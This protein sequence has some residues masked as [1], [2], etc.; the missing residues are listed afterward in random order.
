MMSSGLGSLADTVDMASLIWLVGYSGYCASKAALNIFTLKFA[1]EPLADGI[2][3]NAVDP[4]FTATDLNGHTGHRFVE[5][6][7]TIA[8]ELATLGPLGPTCGFFNDGQAARLSRYS[9]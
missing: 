9:W 1:K 3:V 7:A 5:E 4:G 2:K 6:A 8:V